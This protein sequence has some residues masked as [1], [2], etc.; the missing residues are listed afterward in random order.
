VHQGIRARDH[1]KKGGLQ[2]GRRRTSQGRE[3]TMRD[4]F[5]PRMTLADQGDLGAVIMLEVGKLKDWL[6]RIR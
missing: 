2:K 4:Q 3:Q 1:E 5:S 6:G